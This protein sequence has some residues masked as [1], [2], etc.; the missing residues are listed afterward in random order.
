MASNLSTS[1]QDEKREETSM[2]QILDNTIAP[3]EIFPD[4]GSGEFALQTQSSPDDADNDGVDNDA[5]MPRTSTQEGAKVGIAV[6]RKRKIFVPAPA[7]G[8]AYWL[9]REKNTL[10][11]KKSRDKRRKKEAEEAKRL[12]D[13]N[14]ELLKKI[15]DLEARLA[16]CTCGCLA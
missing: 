2:S 1:V 10:A 7:R 11:A 12:L 13:Q 15:K 14:T 3:S 8:T 4:S 6:E 5:V 16:K 9:K